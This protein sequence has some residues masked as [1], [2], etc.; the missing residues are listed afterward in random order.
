VSGRIKFQ[1]INSGLMKGGVQVVEC[2]QR[3]QRRVLLAMMPSEFLKTF[4][5][6]AGNGKSKLV[7]EE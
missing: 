7:V 3:C 1:R 2:K 6:L 4:A 5:A